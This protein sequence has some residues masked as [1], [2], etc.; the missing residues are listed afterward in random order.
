[1]GGVLGLTNLYH[2]ISLFEQEKLNRHLN[3]RVKFWQHKRDFGKIAAEIERP[4]LRTLLG[5]LATYVANYHHKDTAQYFSSRTIEETKSPR[6][7]TP[8]NFDTVSCSTIRESRPHRQNFVSE[9][10]LMKDL[11]L[12]RNF[13]ITGLFV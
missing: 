8:D 4:R 12:L 3:D 11:W 2:Y 6:L 9:I 1:M 5:E 13:L 7:Q 10:C